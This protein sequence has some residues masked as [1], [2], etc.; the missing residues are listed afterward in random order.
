MC[1]GAL[2]F[3]TTMVL[4]GVPTT[5][6]D[7]QSALCNVSQAPLSWPLSHMRTIICWCVYVL[8]DCITSALY[9][10]TLTLPCYSTPP[11]NSLLHSLQASI[12]APSLGFTLLFGS[13]IVKTW[14]IYY[15]FGKI[16]QRSLNKAQIKFKVR[17]CAKYMHS[18]LMWTICLWLL[19]VY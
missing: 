4:L 14:R 12:W 17:A 9:F 10:A 11:C 16:T 7:V 19:C 15:I 5:S 6:I 13:L 8:V 2:L 18:M 3:Y 1:G